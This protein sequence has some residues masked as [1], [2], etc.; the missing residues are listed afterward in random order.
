MKKH[1]TLFIAIAAA[2]GFTAASHAQ[3]AGSWV[4]NAGVVNIAPKVDSGNLSAPSL[5]N[6]KID[7]KQATT[8]LVG[9]TYMVTDNWSAH[10]ALGWPPR[11]EI[12]GAGAINGVGSLGS[13]VQYSPTLLGQYR[14]FEA[15]DQFRPYLGAGATFVSFGGGKGTAALTSLTNP[16]G[17]QTTP[18][19]DNAFGL[20]L[21]GGA[22]YAINDK[23]FVDGNIIK[24]FIKVKNKLSTG[25]T[26]DAKLDPLSLGLSVGY[27]F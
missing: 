4:V 24:T 7:V 11:H 22:S 19:A 16:G 18:S 5:P 3:S 23:W 2:C 14:F 17:S 20:S 12:V 15:K 25:Q 1:T 26:L 13:I 6:T 9:V 21:Q 8:V 10:L 27:R